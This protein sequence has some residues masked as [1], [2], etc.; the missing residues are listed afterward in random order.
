MKLSAIKTLTLSAFLLSTTAIGAVAADKM[1]IGQ[2]TALIPEAST[3]VDAAHNSV[4]GASG[5]VAFPYISAIKPLAT[6]GEV[7]KETGQVLTGYPDG[8]AAWLADNDTVRVAYQSESYG[9]MSSETVAQKMASGATFTG[10]QVHFIDYDR[11]GLAE[12]LGNDK[13]AADIV[14]GSGHLYSTIYNVF[15]E[16]VKPKAD[17]GKWGN[18][19]KPDGT[20]V[21]Y[22]PKMLLTEADFFVNSFCGA[23]YE[24]ANKYGEGI[25][26]A[27]DA[28]HDG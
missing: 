6:V 24:P 25:G 28:W 23:F 7:D 12:I 11:A 21:D 17:G 14:K 20:V 3:A 16:E 26:F 10:S 2:V 4:D 8:Q 19:T 15:G 27:D 1:T 13:I 9:P 18:Q 22:A 5:D